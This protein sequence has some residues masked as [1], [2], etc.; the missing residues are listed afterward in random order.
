MIDQVMARITG[1]FRRVERRAS[2]RSYLLELQSGVERE[3]GRQMAEQAGHTRPGS[4]QRL[5]RYACWD[6]DALRDDL[7][8]YAA[9]HLATPDGF[10]FVDET[11][12]LK[13]GRSFH[14][15]AG[16]EPG[17]RSDRPSALPAR[18]LV[19]R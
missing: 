4:P 16:N 2:A 1:R 5:L 19:G 7:R 6:A 14:P 12:F 15:C 10:L 18:A 9:E 13:T 8:S 17:T 3:N 11:G